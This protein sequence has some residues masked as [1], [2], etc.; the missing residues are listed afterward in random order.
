MKI[1]FTYNLRSKEKPD[2]NSPED[3][4]G[5]YESDETIE[6]ITEALEKLGHEV[7]RIGDITSLVKFLAEG[8]RVDLVF[9]MAEGRYGRARESQVPSILEAYQ[10]PYTFSDPLTLAICLDKGLT[11][12]ILNTAKIPTPAHQILVPN[13]SIETTLPFPLFVKP[14]YEGASKGINENAI[15][16]TEKELTKRTKWLWKNYKQ[17]VLL[18][19]CLSGR[20]FTVGI[21]GTGKNAH[22]IGA[23]E[24]I[25]KENRKVYDFHV[26]ENYEELTSYSFDIKSPLKEK[27]LNIALKSW[28]A[29]QCRDGGRVDIRLD[30]DG[31]PHVLEI[32]TLPGLHHIHSDLPIIA[33]SIGMSFTELLDEILTHAIK[34]V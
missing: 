16:H 15:I 20:E 31:N 4:Y 11:K 30:E 14:L 6:G 19:K 1:G 34:R 21:L 17:S 9:N 12:D 18:E 23:M 26:K 13:A 25:L 32:N 3:Y 10:I 33:R 29:L 24:I 5:E 7:I 27:L 2:K 28:Q 8:Q 22:A